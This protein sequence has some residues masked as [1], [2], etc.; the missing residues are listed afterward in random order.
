MEYILF[1]VLA[2]VASAANT[3]FNRF[4][5]NN[6]STALSA[7]IKSFLIIIACFA[8][9]AIRGHVPTLYSLTS[10]QWLW[11]GLTGLLTSSN[12]IFY[13]AAIKRSHLEAFSPF[14]ETSQIF[15]SNIMF[16]LPPLFMTT[17]HNGNVLNVTLYIIGLVFL[18][19][20]LI[21]IIFNK[22]INPK[23]KKLWVIYAFIS[24][25]SLAVTVFIVKWKIPDDIVPSDVVSFQQ[26]CIVFVICLVTMFIKKEHKNIPNLKWKEIGIFAIAAIFN[27][28]LMICRYKALSYENAIPQVVTMIVSC[29]FILVSLFA[30]IFFKSDNKKQMLLLISVVLVGLTFNLLAGIL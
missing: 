26:M 1:A 19:G 2:L 16:L 22:K 7:V 6:V 10:E 3:I 25:L 23:A 8:V 11:I 5:S 14:E 15:L 13:F 27:A 12:W 30:I 9:C 24:A 18:A 29:E 4:S 28:A 20:A 21:L 17:T